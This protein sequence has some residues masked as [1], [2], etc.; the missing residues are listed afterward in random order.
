MLPKI[1]LN[2]RLLIVSDEWLGLVSKVFLEYFGERMS[3]TFPHLESLTLVNF[4]PSSLK[5]FLNC[6]TNLS[7]LTEL[8]I[9]LLL[10]PFS[11]AE[12][13]WMLLHQLFTCNNNRLT[14]II[15]DTDSTS[16][17]CESEDVNGSYPNIEKLTMKLN[18]L[19]DFHNLLTIL[20]KIHSLDVII[21]KS[22]FDNSED[23]RHS[24]VYELNEFRLGANFLWNL[25]QLTTV[26]KRL[27]NVENLSIKISTE[28]DS[29]LA[30]SPEFFDQLSSLPLK[31]LD[32]FL[33]Y[34]DTS[35]T[36][37]TLSSTWQQF[38]QEPISVETHN[39]VGSMLYTLPRSPVQLIIPYQF[40]TVMENSELI[41]N[42]RQTLKAL[43]LYNFPPDIAET[44][45]IL[46]KCRRIN[47]L[48]I[49]MDE[50]ADSSKY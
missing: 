7:K 46:T 9:R 39:T 19:Q 14:S 5:I 2:I 3:S 23:Q 22:N 24:P 29:R 45:I 10:E 47:H 13:S 16:F 28:N 21:E 36:K 6:L 26:I 18:S 30:V 20:S 38:R 44:Y 25:E 50:D 42:C 1:G 49:S 40:I 11:D 33:C 15:F 48:T 41:N 43:S 17:F 27:P 34:F 12:E 35:I 32:Y 31:V 37:T 8:N 4:T